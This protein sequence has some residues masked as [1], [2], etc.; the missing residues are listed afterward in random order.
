MKAERPNRGLVRLR[1]LVNDNGMEQTRVEFSVI[2]PTYNRATCL[3]RA[4]ESVL[5]QSY[6]AAEIIVVDDGS[7]DK[8]ARL[9]RENY[10]EVRYHYQRHAGVSAARRSASPETATR[11]A[12]W[13]HH[14]RRRSPARRDHWRRVFPRADWMFRAAQKPIYFL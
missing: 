10:P 12:P 11:S 8:T 4:L 7:S 1:A 3:A 2:I 5:M 9:I 14:R 13:V 6:P